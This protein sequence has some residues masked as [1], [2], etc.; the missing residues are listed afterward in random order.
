MLRTAGLDAYNAWTTDELPFNS[1][2]VKNAFDLV[3]QM[4]FTEGYV[5]G[6]STAIL[7]TAQSGSPWT[8]CSTTTL[9]NPGCWMQQAGDVVRT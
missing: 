6:G 5:L 7:A 9:L 2:E 1:P 8:R 3:G 4:F